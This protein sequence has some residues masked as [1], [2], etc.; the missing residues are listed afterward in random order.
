MQELN[1]RQANVMYVPQIIPKDP[2]TKNDSEGFLNNLMD[3]CTVGSG[4]VVEYDNC[5]QKRIIVS[6]GLVVAFCVLITKIK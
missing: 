3:T 6:A 2:N 1:L 4:T 5:T